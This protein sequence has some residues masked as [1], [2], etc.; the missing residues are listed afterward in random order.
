MVKKPKV[1]APAPQRVAMG[2]ICVHDDDGTLLEKK[3]V[4]LASLANYSPGPR[5]RVFDHPVDTTPGLYRWTGSTY[6]LKASRRDM[7]IVAAE[8]LA[9][10]LIDAV[11]ALF[12]NARITPPETFVA[13]CAAYRI[14]FDDETK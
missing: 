1:V 14:K 8:D 2:T 4:P 13:A 3:S 6:A 12:V 11:E 10:G 9:N 7:E 5:E